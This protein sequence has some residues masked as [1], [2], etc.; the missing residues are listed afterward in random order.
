MFFRF[1]AGSKTMTGCRPK[2]G[3]AS[4]QASVADSTDGPVRGGHIQKKRT[5][6][7]LSSEAKPWMTHAPA[8]PQ[9]QTASHSQSS[10]VKT[11]RPFYVRQATL[12]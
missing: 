3:H 4:N 5:P 11:C 6:G 10:R 7:K 2:G 8:G 9:H 12:D 1:G